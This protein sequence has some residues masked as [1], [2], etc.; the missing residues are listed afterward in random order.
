MQWNISIGEILTEQQAPPKKTES[1]EGS[2][3]LTT[4][5]QAGLNRRQIPEAVG[6]V[7]GSL[8]MGI[9]EQ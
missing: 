7:D 2:N 1:R 8:S 6:H 4:L 9:S 5:N 3:L